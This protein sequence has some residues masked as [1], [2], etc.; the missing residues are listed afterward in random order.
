MDSI[1][2]TIA[3]D[4]AADIAGYVPAAAVVERM[5]RREARFKLRSALRRVTSVQRLRTCGLPLGSGIVVRRKDDVHHFAGVPRKREG[6]RELPGMSTCGSAWICPVCAAKIRYHRADEVSR[7]VVAALNQ[8]MG[9]LFVTRTIPHSAEDKLGVTLG[10]LAE[11]RRYVANQKLVKGARK[12]AGYLGG[13]AAKEITYGLQGWHPHS[14]D[15]DFYKHELTLEHFAALSS[16]YY[17][18]L[19]W[20]YSQNGFDGLSR[21]H[22]VRV[23]HV[24]LGGDALARYVAKLQEGAAIRLHAAHELT[25]ADLKQGRAGSLMPFDIAC[26]FFETGDMA[27]LELYHEYERETKGKS[28]IRFTEGL[29]ARLLPNE[30]DKSDPELAAEEVGGVEVVRFAGWFYR[31]IARVPGLEGKILT[32]L[33]TGGFPALV[34]LLTVYRLDDPDKYQWLEDEATDGVG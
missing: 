17:D 21:Q 2:Q 4:V 12:A 16:V 1:G 20:F 11:G 32:A 8:G 26:E 28:A 23:E 30:P 5:Q 10:L 31:K 3:R 7:A 27:L 22:G 19:E 6:E 18:Y 34:E 29:R 33:D 25:R 14:H 13:I 15:L 9:A 24:Q